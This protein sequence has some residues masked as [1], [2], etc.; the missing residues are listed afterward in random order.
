MAFGK[1]ESPYA[2]SAFC[3][4]Y[5]TVLIP[6]KPSTHLLPRPPTLLFQSATIRETLPLLE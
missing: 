5:G 6:S 1:G 4:L 2:V 3:I